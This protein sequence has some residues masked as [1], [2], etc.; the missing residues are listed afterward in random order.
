MND[1]KLLVEL[2]PDSD[3]SKIAAYFILNGRQSAT[4]NDIAEATGLSLNNVRYYC[5]R[6]KNW[7]T[8]V[9][10]KRHGDV[11]RFNYA[12]VE[13]EVSLI[14]ASG[15]MTEQVASLGNKTIATVSG[16]AKSSTDIVVPPAPNIPDLKTKYEFFHKPTY[17]GRLASKVTQH[18][19]HVSLSGPPGIG[20]SVAFEVLAI[21]NIMPLVN[22]NADAG[23]RARQLVGGMTDL[24]RFEMAQFAAAVVN[25]WWAKIDEA[26]GADP[27]AIIF[28]N[29]ILAPP[30]QVNINGRSY[31][32]HPNFRLCITYNPGLIGTKP[33]PDSLKDRLYPFRVKFPETSQLEKM[34]KGNGLPIEDV[35]VQ[36]MIIFAAALAKA[37]EEGRCKF[38]ITLRRLIDAWTDVQDGF[39]VYDALYN[40]CVDRIDN[41]VDAAAVKTVL[42]TTVQK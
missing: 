27:D 38:D 36:Q 22:I 10:S 14:M 4:M 23:L 31:S 8:N 9:T 15:S 37:R 13:P 2:K 19:L 30:Y 33:L 11:I 41:V 17:F 21:Q 6:M 24:G 29:S 3:M 40:A 16:T 7:F 34:L 39:S 20:K 32:V 12:A 35:K 42:D 26:N 25:G 18:K 28:L 5:A 1:K